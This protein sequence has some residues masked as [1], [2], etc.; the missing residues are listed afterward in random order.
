MAKNQGVQPPGGHVSGQS[1]RPLS[2]PAHALTYDQVAAELDADILSGLSA[3]E[4]KVRLEQYGK[5]DLGEE[6]GVQPLKIVIAQIANAMTMV[7][8]S[9]LQRL[10]AKVLISKNRFL[11]LPWPSALVSNLGSRA[12]S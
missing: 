7:T 8:V 1:N 12:A 5:N 6:E 2:R 9:T 3:N 10:M 11:S 4:V